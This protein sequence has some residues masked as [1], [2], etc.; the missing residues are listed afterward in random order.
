MKTKI[1]KKLVD[2]VKKILDFSKYE[3]G[4]GIKILTHN[5]MLQRL[6]KA[7]AQVKAGNTS[8]VL[9]N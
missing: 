8:E 1:R 6:Q 2:I 5:Q 9:L 7:I 3:N 4:K